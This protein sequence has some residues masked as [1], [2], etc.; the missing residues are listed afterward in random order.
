VRVLG[1]YV[2]NNL[3]QTSVWT[4]TLEKIDAKLK[5]WKRSHPT[6]D[7][8]WLIISMEIGGLTQYLT[9]VQGMPKEVEDSINWKITKFLWDNTSAM[10]NLETMTQPISK[11]G[12]KIL[13]IKS[14]NEAI[15]LMKIKSYLNFSPEHPRW[16]KVADMLIAEISLKASKAMSA[17][18]QA[19]ATPSCKH[20]R[21]RRVGTLIFPTACAG[22]SRWQK[23]TM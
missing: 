6:Q 22:C 1:A 13:D 8:K 2:G 5:R 17:M 4:P 14:R 16:A 10:V 21:P 12:K 23:N 18:K 20:G 3:S 11:G 9:R 19:N 7:G 15:E